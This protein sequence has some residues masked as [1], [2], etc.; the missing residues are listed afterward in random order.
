MGESPNPRL[1]IESCKRRLDKICGFTH[2][3]LPLHD[4]KS[5]LIFCTENVEGGK[6]YFPSPLPPP[7]PEALLLSPEPAA[8]PFPSEL[9]TEE[10]GT[11]KY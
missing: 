8:L 11:L 1:K 2:F 5:A 10:V 6:S 7:F 3:P 4:F 9:P